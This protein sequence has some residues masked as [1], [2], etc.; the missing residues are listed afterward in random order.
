M[1]HADVFEFEVDFDEVVGEVRWELDDLVSEILDEL[2][3]DVGN[4]GL[5]SD[6]YVL[7]QKVDGLLLLE[8]WLELD[9]LL[10]F[11]FFEDVSLFEKLI[12]LLNTH[13]VYF[14]DKNSGHFTGAFFA[15][16]ER[17]MVV[18]DDDD[19]SGHFCFF[20]LVFN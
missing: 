7:K 11:E 19:L 2:I 14:S 5:Q 9:K 1:V 16:P 13:F 18:H 4:P 12:S 20:G 17:V 3:V 15:L 8:H 6:G 10:R